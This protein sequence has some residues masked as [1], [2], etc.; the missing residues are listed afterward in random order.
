[1]PKYDDFEIRRPL[2]ARKIVKRRKRNSK[3]ASS[4]HKNPIADRRKT[5][6][7]NASNQGR[8]QNSSNMNADATQDNPATQSILRTSAQAGEAII[9]NGGVKT[10]KAKYYNTKLKEIRKE[11]EFHKLAEIDLRHNSE[12]SDLL[13]SSQCTQKKGN[14][15]SIQAFNQDEFSNLEVDHTQNELRKGKL[16]FYLLNFI[17]L[18]F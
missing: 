4:A 18:N 17:F 9:N 6:I 1:M 16:A 10:V 7:S 2:K 8:F 14:F 12:I 11:P 15:D 5:S 13:A 3:N